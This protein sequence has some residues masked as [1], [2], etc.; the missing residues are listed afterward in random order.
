MRSV[1]TVPVALGTLVADLGA[2]LAAFEPL[3]G[4]LGSFRRRSSMHYLLD[5]WRLLGRSWAIKSD[6]STSSKGTPGRSWGDLDR[7][8]STPGTSWGAPGRSWALLGRPWPLYFSYIIFARHEHRSKSLSR[9]NFEFQ[10]QF[11]DALGATLGHSWGDPGR[12]WGHLGRPW[13]IPGRSWGA[14]GRS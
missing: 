2:L 3:L 5:S 7:S 9:G 1:G 14:P 4:G 6:L 13:G 12:S 8:W 11:L 10:G